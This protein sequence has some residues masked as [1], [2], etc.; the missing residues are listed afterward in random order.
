MYSSYLRE[1][2]WVEPLNLIK[3]RKTLEL[4]RLRCTYG[5]ASGKGHVWKKFIKSKLYSRLCFLH[6]SPSK[7]HILQFSFLELICWDNSSSG[8]R[9]PHQPEVSY[10]YVPPFVSSKAWQR[11][12]GSHN[13]IME[14][15]NCSN[16]R[17]HQ[18][19]LKHKKA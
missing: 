15:L 14:T 19:K 2:R 7:F 16:S 18:T 8:V 5:L 3:L 17:K 6:T 12:R 1:A 10:F 4:I 13:S 11:N 9:L